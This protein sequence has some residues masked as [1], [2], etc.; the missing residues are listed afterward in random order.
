MRN[1]ADGRVEAVFEG[2]ADAVNAVVDWCRVGP[3]RAAV[4][5]LEVEEEAPRSETGFTIR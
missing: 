2:Q 4:E 3:P 5:Q 1:L